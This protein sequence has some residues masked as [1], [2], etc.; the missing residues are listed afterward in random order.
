MRQVL[1]VMPPM[2]DDIWTAGKGM[3]KIEPA[4]ADGGEVI[5]YAPHITEVSVTH[6]RII[7]EIG[8]HCRDYFLAQ[9][10]RFAQYPGGVLAH[11]THVKGMGTYDAATGVETPRVT[12]DA[13]HRHFRGAL[14]ADQPRLPRSRRRSTSRPG[15]AAR[16]KASWSSRAR[17]RC[18]TG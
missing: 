3:Y 1:S 16:R 12:R 11:S 15:R 8:Y 14:P 9:P 18:S 2:Y 13:R 5:I 4:V 17:A 7:E 10:E 6:G